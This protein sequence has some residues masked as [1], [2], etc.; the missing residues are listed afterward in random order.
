MSIIASQN[1]LMAPVMFNGQVY[2]T[3]QYFHRM[4][5]AN[6][7]D[8]GK[9]GQ[10][11][12]FNRIVRSIEA[13]RHYIDRADIVELKPQDKAGAEFAPAI[14]ELFRLTFGK[15]NNANQRHGTGSLDAPP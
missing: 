2:F 6:T 14:D 12:D 1:P 10:L 11:K 7:K 8:S 3:S 9:Y 13:Y 4:Y 15:T 5:H